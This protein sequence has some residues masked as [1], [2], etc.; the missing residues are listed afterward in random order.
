VHDAIYN[1]GNVG[2]R[3][4]GK[5]GMRDKRDGGRG[6]SYFGFANKWLIKNYH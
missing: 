6:N 3:R 1:S 5:G 4:G 2:N